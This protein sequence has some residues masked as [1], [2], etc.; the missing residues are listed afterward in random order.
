MLRHHTNQTNVVRI[1]IKQTVQTFKFEQSYDI[2]TTHA[3]FVLL[4]E[5]KLGSDVLEALDDCSPPLAVGRAIVATSKD[6]R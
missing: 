3:G 4:G 1:M 2:F 5:F 6:C